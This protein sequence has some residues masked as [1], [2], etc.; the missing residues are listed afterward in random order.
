MKKFSE[1]N[2]GTK[3]TMKETSPDKPY[4]QSVVDYHPVSSSGVVGDNPDTPT[5]S[6][7][8]KGETRKSDDNIEVKNKDKISKGMIKFLSHFVALCICRT[9]YSIFKLTIEMTASL[10]EKT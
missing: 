10:W 9:K 7:L 3:D 4:H 1:L 2:E 6:E 5:S 8:S